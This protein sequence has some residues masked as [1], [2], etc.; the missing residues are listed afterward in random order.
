MLR[1]GMV[2]CKARQRNATNATQTKC[3]LL[4]AT[5]FVK[6]LNRTD[7]RKEETAQRK[8]LYAAF[9]MHRKLPHKKKGRQERRKGKK[10][11]NGN[12]T[13]VCCQRDATEHATLKTGQTERHKKK[14]FATQWNDVRKRNATGT[15]KRNL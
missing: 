6:L 11:R 7:K 3:G 5:E 1:N 2:L 4:D 14:W 9:D 15:V 13:V 8:L 12:G 10:R